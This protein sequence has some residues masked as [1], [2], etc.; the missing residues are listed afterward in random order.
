MRLIACGAVLAVLIGST[1]CASSEVLRERA[2][3]PCGSFGDPA[4]L[5][6]NTAGR[7]VAF[8]RDRVV[9]AFANY[10]RRD[11]TCHVIRGVVDAAMTPTDGFWI[12]HGNVVDYVAPL[13]DGGSYVPRTIRPGGTADNVQ[14]IALNH[15][16]QIEIAL[17]SG[18]NEAKPRLLLFDRLANGAA[19]PL[20]T[21]ASSQLSSPIDSIAFDARGEL[22]AYDR[23][24]KVLEFQSNANGSDVSPRRII[25]GW[26]TQLRPATAA[27]RGTRHVVVDANGNLIATDAGIAITFA[28]NASGNA[29]PVDVFGTDGPSYGIALD[30]AGQVYSLAHESIGIYAPLATRLAANH[31]ASSLQTLE[32]ER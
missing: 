12:A 13:S 25:A 11:A 14:A 29:T 15:A 10:A 24:G 28:A 31:T 8:A 26:R 18:G 7:P 21:V 32:I 1:F 6:M 16:Q 17:S 27:S 5:G 3:R 30:R 20:R 19:T 9:W 22:Y 4:A 23:S 2:A